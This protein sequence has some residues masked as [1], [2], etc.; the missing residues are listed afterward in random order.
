MAQP[1]P[2][3]LSSAAFWS[4]AGGFTQQ[5]ST[6]AIF[7]V[8]ARLLSPREFG[9]MALAAGAMDV[10]LVLARAGIPELIL[11]DRDTDNRRLSTAFWM[12]LVFGAAAATAL[13]GAA[14]FI[15]RFYAI[16]ELEDL[17]QLLALVCILQA[18]S[19]THEA[20]I[21]R[22]LNYKALTIRL[23]MAS[24]VGGIAAVLLAFYGAGV[25]ALLAQR[26]FLAASLSFLAWTACP[27]RPA[28]KMSWH[29][30]RWIIAH[31][32]KLSAGFTL[33]YLAPKVMEAILA[34][35]LG[36]ATLGLYRIASRTIDL[37]AA[38]AVT[39]MAQLA[40][41]LL[42]HYKDHPEGHAKLALLQTGIIYLAAPIV[43]GAVMVGEPLIHVV[44]GAKWEGAGLL[45]A[46][47]SPTLLL[48]AAATTIESI[49]SAY[50]R[51]ASVITLN[52]FQLAASAVLTLIAVPF[53]ATGV[54]LIQTFR[55]A[56]SA[57]VAFLL[58]RPVLPVS[59]IIDR[60]KFKPLIAALTAELSVLVLIS[61][62]WG[63]APIFVTIFIAG[64]A[65]VIPLVL[66]PPLDYGRIWHRHR[67][68]TNNEMPH[69]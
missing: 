27:W 31:G 69:A 2:N 63:H 62:L 28:C 34:A 7:V 55:G 32:P 56:L 61:R 11:Q 24:T 42:T 26:I 51:A 65:Y 13:L 36:P 6:F 47:L 48:G 57:L 59:Q 45:L 49:L 20:L 16:P 43:V 40:L 67:R 3:A 14:P 66:F 29:D 23:G 39:P 5:I 33:G 38:V 64:L 19:L 12:S 37:I 50:N 10:L 54:A 52:G 1:R 17:C 4:I 22:T 15:A 9:I 25:Y 58:A 8:L 68:D 18:F 53:G 35:K 41:P 21:K 30:A 60:V 44:Y 46:I